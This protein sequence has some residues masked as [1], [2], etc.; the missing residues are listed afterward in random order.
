T[1]CSAGARGAPLRRSESSEFGGAPPHAGTPFAAFRTS[2]RVPDE[3]SL[4]SAVVGARFPWG[5]LLRTRLRCDFECDGWG[6]AFERYSEIQMG[7]VMQ[8]SLM[9]LLKRALAVGALEV[10]LVPGRRTIVVLPQGENE[11][12]GDPQ[13]PERITEFIGPVMTA[14]ARRALASGWAEWDFQLDGYGTIRACAELKL[15]L[16]HVSLFLDRCDQPQPSS[17]G[18]PAQ[19]ASGTHRQPSIPEVAAVS[20]P[21]DPQRPVLPTVPPLSPSAQVYDAGMSAGSTA[22]IDRLLLEMLKV[23]AS[24]LHVT[25]GTIPMVRV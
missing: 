4:S 20:E 14:E 16:P 10:R 17:R 6:G 25:A 19:R 8:L 22:E 3:V 13:T 18:G 9:D 1:P 24:D 12:K 15:G 7:T 23:K 5:A 21:R 2:R 11:V